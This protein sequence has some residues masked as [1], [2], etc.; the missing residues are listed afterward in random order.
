MEGG[1]PGEEEKLQNVINDSTHRGGKP[2]ILLDSHPS[3]PCTLTIPRAPRDFHKT[4][5]RQNRGGTRSKISPLETKQP[6][7]ESQIQENQPLTKERSI[8]QN[9]PAC[10]VLFQQKGVTKGATKEK[11]KGHGTGGGG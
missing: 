4:L 1:I 3:P 11:G 8:N 6:Q 10:P 9:F 2:P 5:K 7:N